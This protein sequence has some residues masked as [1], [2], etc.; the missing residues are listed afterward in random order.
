MRFEHNKNDKKGNPI[1]NGLNVWRNLGL[2]RKIQPLQ[3]NVNEHKPTFIKSI[4]SIKGSWKAREPKETQSNVF[5][6]FF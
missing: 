3:F 4:I 5:N 1:E 6:S 2:V